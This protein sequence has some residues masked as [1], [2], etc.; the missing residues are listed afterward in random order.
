MHFPAIFSRMCRWFPRYVIHETHVNWKE[1]SWKITKGIIYPDVEIRQLYNLYSL[2]LAFF[3]LRHFLYQLYPLYCSLQFLQSPKYSISHSPR[4]GNDAQCK[5][6]SLSFCLSC[7]RLTVA[8]SDIH[9]INKRNTAADFIWN[10][11]KPHKVLELKMH[12]WIIHILVTIISVTFSQLFKLFQYH[13]PWSLIDIL[14]E[15][16]HQ[17][18]KLMNSTTTFKL[19]VRSL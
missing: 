15:C 18:I 1:S 8:W 9:C 11:I 5:I 6:L 4:V 13:C 17:K 16:I 10:E 3:V 2:F 12:D 19:N 14:A 7:L